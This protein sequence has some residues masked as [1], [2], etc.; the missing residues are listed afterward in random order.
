MQE[1]FGDT[2]YRDLFEDS[3]DAVYVSSFE[4][5]IL[6]INK[7]GVELFG[8]PREEI[9]GMDIRALYAAPYDRERFQRE[10]EATGAVKDFE[11]PLLR[12][13]GTRI[14]C[15]ITST[16]RRSSEGGIIG[17]QGIIRDVTAY[18][19]AEEALRR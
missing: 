5:N 19:K 2:C 18:K 15:I 10:I 3:M 17:Y 12:K 16:A 1:Q 13:D 4:G 7:A 8:Y 9:M 14:I 11:V 6:A